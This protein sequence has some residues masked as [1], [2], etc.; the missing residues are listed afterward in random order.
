MPKLISIVMSIMILGIAN[1]SFAEETKSQGFQWPQ[2]I[3]W[4]TES[5]PFPLEFA[6]DIQHRGTVEVRFSPGFKDPDA[7]GFWSYAFVWWLED[8]V[9]L[10]KQL[11]ADELTRYYLGLS[12]AV[13]GDKYVI[14]A[15]DF[16]A[17]F[18]DEI[19]TDPDASAYRGAIDSFDPFKTGKPIR[20]NVKL[21]VGKCEA[22]KRRFVLVEAS[23]QPLNAAIWKELT[24]VAD[25]FKCSVPTS[26]KEK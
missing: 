15:E 13:A 5:I 26:E 9:P 7:P 1:S 23:P 10:T 17:D 16:K 11:L 22:A 18:T 8:E 21:R 4:R 20:L 24:Q 14:H 2:P 19:V 3:G 12:K 25:S 6:P